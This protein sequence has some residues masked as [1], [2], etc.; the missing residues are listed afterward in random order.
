MKEKKLEI[1]HSQ[2]EPDFF[3]EVMYMPFD[4]EINEKIYVIDDLSIIKD[5]FM[6]VAQFISLFTSSNTKKS[7]KLFEHIKE[8]KDFTIH[9][10]I[11]IT[12]L[13]SFLQSQN[14][15]NLHE[16]LEIGVRKNCSI[17]L[18][19]ANSTVLHYR[20]KLLINHSITL[21]NDNLQDISALFELPIKKKV[22]S[23]HQGLTRQ[24]NILL[25]QFI[26]VD[27][28]NLLTCIEENYRQY[29]GIKP[30][31]LPSIPE[32]I[33]Y[34][35]YQGNELPLGISLNTFNWII[36]SKESVLLVI[37]TYEYELYDFY[38]V[39]KETELSVLLLPVVYA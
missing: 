6:R 8:K 33:S 25:F 3:E 11:I 37:S 26:Q 19:S 2:E 15:S 31:I 1:I 28:R 14:T 34:C 22:T 18:F 27:E 38:H 32:K 10:T 13:Y 36:V 4:T 16:L 35:N 5:D 30:Y 9:T 17:L 21:R 20:E 39:L 24:E 7:N 29:Q 23:S 12:D